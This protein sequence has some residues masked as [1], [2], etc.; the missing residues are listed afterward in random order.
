MS[1]IEVITVWG[2]NQSGGHVQYVISTHNNHYYEQFLLP[3]EYDEIGEIC[4]AQNMEYQADGSTFAPAGLDPLPPGIASALR[5][6]LGAVTAHGDNIMVR[7]IDP[8][9]NVDTLP[10][11]EVIKDLG[12]IAVSVDTIDVEDARGSHSHPLVTIDLEEIVGGS[13]HEP[14][15]Y[16]PAV[17]DTFLHELLHAYQHVHQTYSWPS[18]GKHPSWSFTNITPIN[19]LIQASNA[20]GVNLLVN[21]HV[22]EC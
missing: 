16:L 5:A 18:S 7:V 12:Y 15:Q 2:R 22:L 17:Y 19:Q 13:G 1:G 21:D 4:S 8:D 3:K 9:Q 20:V 14:S 6:F 10:M 11:S